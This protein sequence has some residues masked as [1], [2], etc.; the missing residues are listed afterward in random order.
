ML[1]KAS[2]SYFEFV[3]YK[4]ISDCETSASLS[5]K[6]AEQRA[7]SRTVATLRKKIGE[8]ENELNNC[9]PALVDFYQQVAGDVEQ[10]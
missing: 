8:T 7:V 3:L 5:R 9:I 10:K 4:H 6:Y 2:A 1:N